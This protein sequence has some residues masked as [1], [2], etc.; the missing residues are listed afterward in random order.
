[1]KPTTIPHSCIPTGPFTWPCLMVK[2][3]R[4]M[5]GKLVMRTLDVDGTFSK[6]PASCMLHGCINMCVSVFMCIMYFCCPSPHFLLLLTTASPPVIS[7]LKHYL[8]ILFFSLFPSLLSD[9]SSP[10]S[11]SP[12]RTSTLNRISIVSVLTSACS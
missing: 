5:F 9:T 8:S 2:S 3:W 4:Q 10:S 6:T 1:M 11:T 7:L 12:I